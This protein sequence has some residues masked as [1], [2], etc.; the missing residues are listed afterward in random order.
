MAVANNSWQGVSPSRGGR[1]IKQ[2]NDKKVV[3]GMIGLAVSEELL[4]QYEEALES[5]EM[6]CA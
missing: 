6:T 1:P 5:T 2:D 3:K 4:V